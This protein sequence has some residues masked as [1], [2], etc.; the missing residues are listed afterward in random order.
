ME[1][2][3]RLVNGEAADAV[4]LTYESNTT[5]GDLKLLLRTTPHNFDTERV[6]FRI[7]A[8]DGMS[9]EVGDRRLVQDLAERSG[10]L[11]FEGKKSVTPDTVTDEVPDRSSGPADALNTN[12]VEESKLRGKATLHVGD[13][14]AGDMPAWLKKKGVMNRIKKHDAADEADAHVG[15]IVGM[16]R[17]D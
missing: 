1:L 11:S 9:E 15:N 8:A 2:P 16:G 5:V 7:E 6:T 3:I 13:R 12:E 10:T 17:G 14:Y 4:K